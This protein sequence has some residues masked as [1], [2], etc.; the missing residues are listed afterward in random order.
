AKLCFYSLKPGVWNDPYC[1]SYGISANCDRLHFSGT[2]ARVEWWWVTSASDACVS[3][4]DIDDAVEHRHKYERAGL[5][6]DSRELAVQLR[7][8]ST[9]INGFRRMGFDHCAHHRRDQR[10]ADAV[11]HH[12][13]NTNSGCVVVKPCDVKK[14][15]AH[16]GSWYTAVTKEDT[17][18]TGPGITCSTRIRA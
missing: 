15:A 10:R 9:G 12:I 4:P 16:Q 7:Q 17:C 13:A 1:R 14:I 8:E 11:A 5:L 3:H 18:V 6:Q 2:S